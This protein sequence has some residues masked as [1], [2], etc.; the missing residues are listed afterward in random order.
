MGRTAAE[1]APD[2]RL[3]LVE[4]A[5][6]HHAELHQIGAVQNLVQLNQARPHVSP[7]AEGDVVERLVVAGAEAGHGVVGVARAAEHL[8]L[9]PGRRVEGLGVRFREHLEFAPGRRV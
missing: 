5:T 6:P 1:H 2:P 8:E 4:R 9:A 7:F 3:H